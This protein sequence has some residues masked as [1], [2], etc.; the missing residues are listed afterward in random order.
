MFCPKKKYI[1]SLQKI[2]PFQITQEISCSSTIFFGKTIFSEHLKKI[3]FHVLFWERSSF[4]FR[5]K[6]KTI[7]SGKRNII[8]QIIKQ[9][10]SCSSAI[11]FGKT[12]FSEHLKKISHFHVFFWEISSFIFRLKNKKIFSGKRNI[13]FPDNTRVIIFQREFLGK[14][15]LSEYLEKE[16]MVFRA[17][18]QD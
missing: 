2:P 12:I 5:L 9:E 10:R 7:F 1:F 14:T 16:N 15:I 6:N 11:F 4:I 18:L 13:N 3:C 8:F 17:V